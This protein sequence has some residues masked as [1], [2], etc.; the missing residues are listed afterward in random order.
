MKYA[1]IR[2]NGRQYKVSEK[3]EVLIDYAKNEEVKP[4]VLLI[5]DGEKVEVGTPIVTG[6]KVEFKVLAE[7]EK[8]VKIDVIK[9][10]SKSR[11]KKH[12]GFRPVYT[13]ILI[14]KISF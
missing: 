2:I 6:A 7:A 4:E 14:E 9:Y 3:E 8:G 10:K 1:V 11:Y 5:A 12:T 13:R